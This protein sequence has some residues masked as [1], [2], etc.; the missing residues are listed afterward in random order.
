[1]IQGIIALANNIEKQVL[2]EGV[3]TELQKALLRG[4]G[5]KYIQ[6]YLYSKPLPLDELEARYFTENIDKDA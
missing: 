6:G 1:M 3:E 2:A 4:A 5:C